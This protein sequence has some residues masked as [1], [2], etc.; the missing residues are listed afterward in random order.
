M[1]STICTR[2][3]WTGYNYYFK[4][5]LIRRHR[6]P[7]PAP[8][9]ER[10]YRVEDMNVGKDIVLH[11]KIFRITV[12]IMKSWVSVLHV[13]PLRPHRTAM[14]SRGIFSENLVSVFLRLR[15]HPKTPTPCIKGR[16]ELNFVIYILL[17]SHQL[18]SCIKSL[19]CFVPIHRNQPPCSHSGPMTRWT[20][21]DSSWIMTERCW[22]FS[23]IGTTVTRK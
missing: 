10:F 4:G 17:A 2:Q 1:K 18:V 16:Y 19:L 11:G 22:N 9:D 15:P 21:W 20:I 7:L 13:L 14:N 12:R 5:T 6:V 3:Q 23:A 8:N